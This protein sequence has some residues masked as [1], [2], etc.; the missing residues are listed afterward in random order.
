[1]VERWAAAAAVPE[2]EHAT[3]AP[4]AP[5]PPAASPAC[6]A[7]P[8]DMERLN[9]F[10]DGSIESL[11]D[12]LMLYMNQTK[13]QLADLKAAVDSNTTEEVRRI[14]HSCAGASATCGMTEMLPIMRALEKQGFDG[15]LT[16]ASAQ[17]SLAFEKFGI[18]KNYIDN[19]VLRPE[20]A[21]R[22]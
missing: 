18:I 22:A 10:T 4:A 19:Q 2:P 8:I 9:E 16:D 21:A 20:T 15:K 6:P 14:A 11:R 13:G 5:Q 7:C 17:V 12:L 3:S 1:V